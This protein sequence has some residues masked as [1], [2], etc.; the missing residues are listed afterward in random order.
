MQINLGPEGMFLLL[1]NVA[2]YVCGFV[3][4]FVRH[5]SHPDYEKAQRNYIKTVKNYLKFENY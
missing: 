1:I 5:D 2:I 4:A 3:A